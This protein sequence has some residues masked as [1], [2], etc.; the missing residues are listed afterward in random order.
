MGEDAGLQL[1]EH[2]RRLEGHSERRGREIGGGRECSGV[3]ILEWEMCSHGGATVL[4]G[5]VLEV[6]DA[7]GC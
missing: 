6:G 5:W 3:L 1:R 7:I 2:G 4:V